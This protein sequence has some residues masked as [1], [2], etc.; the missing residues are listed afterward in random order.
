MGRKWNGLAALQLAAAC[1]RRADL[2]SVS[3]GSCSSGLLEFYHYYGILLLAAPV[4]EQLSHRRDRR[5]PS[6]TSRSPGRRW[7][8]SR[9]SPPP[10]A[11]TRQLPR[12]PRRRRR[13]RARTATARRTAR[14]PWLRTPACTPPSARSTR[15]P[16]TPPLP[17]PGSP[18][19]P[20]RTCGDALYESDKRS[21]FLVVWVGVNG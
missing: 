5:R 12:L 9:S 16:P 8:A 3:S 11:P 19:A 13:R 10:P 4:L 15:T 18:L 20:P 21:C 14:A 17:R 1:K 6:G 2:R 7:H